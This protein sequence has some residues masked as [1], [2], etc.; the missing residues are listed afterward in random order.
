M[1]ENMYSVYEQSRGGYPLLVTHG[2]RRGPQSVLTKNSLPKVFK[3]V[4]LES[5]QIDG[6]GNRRWLPI[7]L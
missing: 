7:L 6:T 5:A 1:L 4:F 3:G 2:L